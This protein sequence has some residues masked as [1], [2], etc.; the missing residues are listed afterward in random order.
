MAHKVPPSPDRA[1][2]S[3]LLSTP[4]R[5][6][7]LVLFGM[8]M[9]MGCVLPHAN[10]RDS[11][12]S[13]ATSIDVTA[14]PEG[15]TF[16]A[17]GCR[18]FQTDPTHCG[19]CD[20]RCTYTNAVATCVAGQ[21]AQGACDRGF[22]N[23]NMRTDD[24][25]ETALT[26]SL[27][28][29]SCGHECTAPTPDC[30]GA[31]GMC[32]NGCPAGQIRC[33][34]DCVDPMSNQAH[35]GA[36]GAACSLDHANSQCTAGSCTIASCV[37]GFADCDRIAANGCE[38]QLG[39]NTDCMGCRMPCAAPTPNCI[40]MTRTCALVCPGT[41]TECPGI[42]GCI[43]TLSDPNHCGGCNNRCAFANAV[44]ACVAGVC[45]IAGCAPGFRDCD[46]VL[47]NGCELN[48]VADANNC[49]ACGRRCGLANASA[50][51]RSE[52][53]VINQCNR[54]FGDCDRLAANGCEADLNNVANCGNCATR[55]MA[56]NAAASCSMGVC[57]FTGACSPSFGNCD[58]NDANGCETN[59]QTSTNHCGGCGMLC[60]PANV[61]S[62]NCVAGVCGYSGCLV[63]RSDCD[64]N[65]R[66]GCEAD[67]TMDPTH[68][69]NCMTNCPGAPNSAPICVGSTCRT[70]CNAGFGD[71]DN[72]AGTGCEI[73]LATSPLNCGRCGT[74][75]PAR[76]HST[77]TCVAST[78]R[79]ACDPGWAD[80][81]GMAMNGCEVDLSADTN[82]GRC[83][84]RCT[85][86][87]SC[88]GGM[89]TCSGAGTA[90][91]SMTVTCCTMMQN[92]SMGRCM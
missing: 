83:G 9:W 27:N 41:T 7:S 75:C 24:G 85:G 59:I 92:C 38:T 82:C 16:C 44:G 57:G 53:C 86:M 10:P 6:G 2:P 73:N 70:S 56:A 84:V 30:N 13:D 40:P 12:G 52:T 50:N 65:A 90:C 66:N 81:D 89:C 3:S 21:C 67:T 26:S 1:K 49:G 39:T 74:V 17:G 77:A 33:G 32:G 71:C 23:C 11:A 78:C 28:C 54:G 60:S 80:C 34:A 31:T 45:Q 47:A 19:S 29:G 58:N 43:N 22:G 48:V 88:S 51:C 76:A 25:C 87:A 37:D 61:M 62:A 15:T 5:T 42:A 79:I 46:R 68:C 64:G 36:C 91:G 20:R 4:A 63:G 18:A 55:C 14:C 35:C 69:G 8:A 72:N